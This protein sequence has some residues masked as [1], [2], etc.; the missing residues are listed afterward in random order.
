[1][2]MRM[3]K[4]A[5]CECIFKS[6]DLI[7]SELINKTDRFS[8]NFENK[9]EPSNVV[10]MKCIYTLF[11]KSGLLKNLGIH[12][13]FFTILLFLISA[14]LF[15]KCGYNLLE[16]YIQEIIETKK[17]KNEH[18]NFNIKETID[19]MTKQR[20]RKYLIK[21]KN[22]AKNEKKISSRTWSEIKYK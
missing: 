20:K 18:Q 22:Q 9:E 16:D 12:I 8:F 14:I 17:E 2:H 13:L 5:K 3:R 21:P 7:I 19:Q 4:K 1:M 11:T 15:Y 10:T 6:K